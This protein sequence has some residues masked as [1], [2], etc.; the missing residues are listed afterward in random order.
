MDSGSF[1]HRSSHLSPG[2]SIRGGPDDDDTLIDYGDDDSS[3]FEE[4]GSFIG[5]YVTRKRADRERDRLERERLEREAA[6]MA[7]AAAHH[8][9]H[10]PGAA[11]FV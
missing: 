7:A 11:T 4:D 2:S 8:R 10:H 5:Q 1:P 6:A 9:G 3:K